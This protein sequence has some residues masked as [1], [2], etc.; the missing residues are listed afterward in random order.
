MIA[1]RSET[2]DSLIGSGSDA[3]GEDHLAHLRF[4][5]VQFQRTDKLYAFE[6]RLMLGNVSK[7]VKS[8][9]NL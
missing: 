4:T 8:A 7:T 2:P 1:F 9:F 3:A 5:K 6:D